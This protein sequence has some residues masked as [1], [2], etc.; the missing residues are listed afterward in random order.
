MRLLQV[1]YDPQAT[2]CVRLQGA[3]DKSNYLTDP[4][5]GVATRTCGRGD[6]A[7]VEK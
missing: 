2:D 5:V 4:A 6:A 3:E 7:S 1:L